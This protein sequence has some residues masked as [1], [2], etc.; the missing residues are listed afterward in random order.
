M[1]KKCPSELTSL[2]ICLSH[3][4]MIC[5]IHIHKAWSAVELSW[6]APFS[7]YP[8]LPQHWTPS[9]LHFLLSTWLKTNTSWPGE[10]PGRH[11]F[12]QSGYVESRF[13]LLEVVLFLSALALGRG[14]FRVLAGKS[15]ER[16][17]SGCQLDLLA[18][19]ASCPAWT[20]T[21]L[22]SKARSGLPPAQLTSVTNK[23]QGLC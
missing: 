12:L 20:Q 23:P 5:A 18:V 2:S 11:L 19:R 10:T 14:P 8:T 13:V 7:Y 16:T 17:L 22:L 15:G 1:G 9:W 21:V 6:N 3:S 4:E